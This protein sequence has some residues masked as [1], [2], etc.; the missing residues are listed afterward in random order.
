MKNVQQIVDT[1]RCTG[2]S[3]CEL[4]C[5]YGFISLKD[6]DLG[7]PIPVIEKCNDC[8]ACIKSCPFSDEY[9]EDD[10]VQYKHNISNNKNSYNN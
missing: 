10:D 2:C 9:D 3:R 5:R 7:F 6:G 8:G 4:F 1:K